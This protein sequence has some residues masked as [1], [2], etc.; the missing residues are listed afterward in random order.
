MGM[1]GRTLLLF[2]PFL[3]HRLAEAAVRDRVGTVVLVVLDDLGASDL[4]L[5]GWDSR[6]SHADT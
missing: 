4:G 5:Y 6:D 2:V 1:M 3:A